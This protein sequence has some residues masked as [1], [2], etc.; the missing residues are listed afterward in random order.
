MRT[1]SCAMLT[2]LWFLAGVMA[3]KL[4]KKRRLI[5]FLAA[6]LVNYWLYKHII[7][8]GYIPIW[9][10]NLINVTAFFMGTRLCVIGLTGGIACGKSSVCEIL[11]QSGFKIV[12]AD[13]ISH[14]IMHHDKALVSS[15]NK[16]FPGVV[17][18]GKVD[19]AALG[20]IVFAD[21]QKR[22]L[23]QRLTHGP[24]MKAMLWQVFELRVLKMQQLVVLDAPLLF[25]TKILEYLTSPIIVVHAK[26]INQQ[27]K[28]LM[29]RNGI[30]SEEA[31][32]KIK[33]QM[34]IKEKKSKADILIDN[35]GT[36]EA[37]EKFVREK[38][39]K[40]ATEMMSLI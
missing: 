3:L 21:Q 11:K 16:N 40:Q 25:E 36:E 6:W 29:A 2:V 10:S 27:K 35:S 12:D 31:D 23:L 34:P 5:S 30:S 22:K 26:D 33:A 37:L 32:N 15:V 8:V 7:G 18:D 13:L 20:K 39:I 17:I 19:R 24:I 4:S 1:L 28:R 14:E 9:L 38:V